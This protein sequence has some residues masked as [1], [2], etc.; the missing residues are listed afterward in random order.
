M[1]E[2]GPIVRYL[3]HSREPLTAV[4]LTLPLLVLYGLGITLYP[5]AGNGVDLLSQGLFSALGALGRWRWAGYLSFYGGL[6]LA[7]VLLIAHLRNTKQ[8]HPEYFWALLAESAGY[9]VLVGTVSST[10]TGYVTGWVGAATPAQASACLVRLAAAREHGVIDGLIVSAG[11]GLHEELVFRLIGI[12][13]VG[14]AWLGAA[15]NRPSLR[16]LGILVGTAVGFSAVH[17]IVE[18]FTMG[19]FVFRTFAGLLFGGLFLVRGFAV[20]AWTHALY[21]VWVIVVLG[22]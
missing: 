15:W 14:R 4:A 21:D 18:P 8:Y 13:A 22:R 2:S 9:A 17:H 5:Q 20:A 3:R 1:T 6:A 19:A 7:N 12:G 11:A 16:L 10:A